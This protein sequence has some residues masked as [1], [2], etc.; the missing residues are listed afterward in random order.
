MGILAD[1][2][3]TYAVNEPQLLQIRL[4]HCELL[5]RFV[6]PLDPQHSELP[7]ACIPRRMHTPAHAYPGA[8]IPRRPAHAHSWHDTR[9]P[10]APGACILPAHAFPAPGA[11]YSGAFIILRRSAYAYSGAYILPAHAPRRMHTPA[12]AYPGARRSILPAHA[13]SRMHTRRIHASRRI[14]RRPAH[15]HTPAC[16]PRRMHTPGARRMYPAH[17]Y[18]RAC[19][20]RRRNQSTRSAA[21]EDIGYIGLLDTL[22]SFIVLEA[23]LSRFVY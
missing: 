14:P 7:G 16:I 5:F 4:V 15:V 2:M 13:Y 3:F 21:C 18:T 1:S 20:P 23:Q 17:V 8:C 6:T 11:C 9:R 10:A 22:Q 12:H 19:I